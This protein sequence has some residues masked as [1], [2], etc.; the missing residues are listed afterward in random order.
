[1]YGVGLGALGNGSLTYLV[2][3]YKDVSRHVLTTQRPKY[4][5]TSVLYGQLV[6]DGMV[7]VIFV[8]NALATLTSTCLSPWV[9]TMGLRNMFIV[10]GCLSIAILL[11][12]VPMIIWG[13]KCREWTAKRYMTMAAKQSD[14][15][16]KTTPS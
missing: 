2:D 11:L 5:L 3:S 10:S 16:M 12:T 13:R 6:G 9:S 4:Q 14:A 8:R 7:G 1:M 15:R